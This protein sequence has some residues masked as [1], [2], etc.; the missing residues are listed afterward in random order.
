MVLCW[1]KAKYF[2]IYVLLNNFWNTIEIGIIGCMHLLQLR[3]KLL[4][5]FL[6]HNPWLVKFLFNC[7]IFFDIQLY[8]FEQLIIRFQMTSWRNA[9]WKVV[10]PCC[11]F[12]YFTVF[13]SDLIIVQNNFKLTC[14]FVKFLKFFYSASQNIGE[15][16]P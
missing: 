7:I 16:F 1:I 8:L 10:T 15:S 9:K 4:K 6:N 11:N 3:E 14:M 13:S 2:L 12:N 5:I